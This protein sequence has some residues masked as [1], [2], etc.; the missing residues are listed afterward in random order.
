M[1]AKGFYR[2]HSALCFFISLSHV[3]HVLT[4]GIGRLKRRISVL[5]RKLHERSPSL[6]ILRLCDR[7]YTRKITLSTSQIKFKFYQVKHLWD[8]VRISSRLCALV[9]LYYRLKCA[10]F[11]SNANISDASVQVICS[12]CVNFYEGQMNFI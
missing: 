7:K 11:L 9:C 6:D 8:I 12:D 2:L 5:H 3:L 10:H 4:C 1:R